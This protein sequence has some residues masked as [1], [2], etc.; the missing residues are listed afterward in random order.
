MGRPPKA[1]PVFLIILY[2][3]SALQ[4]H[5]LLHPGFGKAIGNSLNCPARGTGCAKTWVSKT[6]VWPDLGFKG[7]ECLEKQ[8]VTEGRVMALEQGDHPACPWNFP[9]WQGDVFGQ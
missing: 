3:I 8:T 6:W 4:A 2:H 1:A 5:V 7:F 9:A